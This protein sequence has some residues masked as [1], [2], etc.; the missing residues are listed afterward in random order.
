MK[1]SISMT[2]FFHYLILGIFPNI[3]SKFVLAFGL[4]S[5][6]DPILILAIDASMPSVRGKRGWAAVTSL[7]NREVLKRTVSHIPISH[8][9]T[10]KLLTASHPQTEK[11][12]TDR[13][14]LPNN[15][16]PSQTNFNT[17]RQRQS[18]TEKSQMLQKRATFL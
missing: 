7:M 2:I 1:Y 11:S 13:H 6:L 10:W 17:L 14:G 8:L 9:V 12:S 18:V 4:Q 5:A 16:Q 3:L 15:H